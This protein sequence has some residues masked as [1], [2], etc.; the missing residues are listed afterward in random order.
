MRSTGIP[1]LSGGRAL[2]PDGSE[3]SRRQVSDDEQGVEDP[4]SNDREQ[5]PVL[6][7]QVLP[8]IRARLEGGSIAQLQR[9]PCDFSHGRRCRVLSVGGTFRSALTR[10]HFPS[11]ERMLPFSGGHAGSCAVRWK[12]R[13]ASRCPPEHADFTDGRSRHPAGTC[14]AIAWTGTRRRGRPSAGKRYP[15]AFDA[16]GRRGSP[17]SPRTRHREQRRGARDPDVAEAPAH[18]GAGPD[19]LPKLST[20]RPAGLQRPLWVVLG[21]GLIPALAAGA[22]VY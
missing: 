11:L 12:C 18:P 19:P 4:E 6:G 15:G 1:P 14:L 13:S 22:G 7:L 10:R 17:R 9:P 21:T 20:G 16:R 5:R 8:P 2:P 3:P